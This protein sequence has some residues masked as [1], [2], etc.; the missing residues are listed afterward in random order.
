MRILK[1][2][3]QNF[4]RNI[5]LSL[6]SVMVIFLMLFSLS[7][8]YSLNVIAQDAVDNF[9]NKVDLGVYLKENANENQVSYLRSE[10]ENSSAVK[11]IHFMTPHQALE[12]FKKRHRDEEIIERALEELGEN[13]FGPAIT[14][15]LNNPNDFQQVLEIIQKPGYQALIKD[16]DFYDYQELIGIFS[17]FSEKI[18]YTGWMISGFFALIVIMVIFNTIKLGIL[19]RKK[20][21]KIMRLVGATSWFIRGPFLVESCLYA[22]IAW[23]T[24][25]VCLIGLAWLSQ[26]YL[27][28]FLETE[29]NLL[30]HFQYQGWEFFGILLFFSLLISVSASSTA[31]KKYLKI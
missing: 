28:K 3:F 22:L 17:R 24:N 15:K 9:K 31:I 1:L 23:I 5:L 10:L 4:I 21:I 19:A 25:A 11:E 27:Q 7:L 30:R 20:E 12:Q 13:P 18:H 14:I 29:F 6:T 16:Q 2:A 26:S 8:L